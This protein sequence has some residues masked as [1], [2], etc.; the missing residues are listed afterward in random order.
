M[1]GYVNDTGL[2]ILSVKT[3]PVSLVCCTKLSYIFECLQDRD[4]T[5]RQSPRGDIFT[6]GDFKDLDRMDH[7]PELADNDPAYSSNFEQWDTYWEDL[8]KYT[9]LT[10]CDIW[11]TKEVDFLG[12]DDFSSPYQDEEVIGRTPTLAQLNSEDSQPVCDTLYHPDLLVGQK[13][14]LF[15]P[16]TVAKK[17]NKLSSS[18]TSASSSRNPLPD[19]PEGSQKATWPVASSTDTMAKAQLQGPSK[20]SPAL[21][22]NMDYVRKAKVR[23]SVPRKPLVE[24]STQ[25]SVSASP[26]IQE[27]ESS[28]SQ[29]SE[30]PVVVAANTASSISCEKRVETPKQEGTDR[31]LVQKIGTLRMMPQTPLPCSCRQETLL[32]VSAL[33][34]DTSAADKRRRKSTTTL[35]FLTRARLAGKATADMEEGEEEEEEGEEEEEEGEKKRTR[36][37]DWI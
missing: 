7:L 14:L 11:G 25:I 30:D 31:V 24:S 16:P 33:G 3:P 34:S 21:L 12:L 10:S 9:R 22:E 20:A 18:A 32:T 6:V 26:L 1:H 37:R 29:V 4:M 23:I 36:Q 19:F 13:Q 17:T 27:H 28:A 2:L 8:T 5:C 15:P 35:L